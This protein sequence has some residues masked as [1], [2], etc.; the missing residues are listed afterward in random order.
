LQPIFYDPKPG[1]RA[2]FPA[3][4]ENIE[5]IDISKVRW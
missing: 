3:E 5:S 4:R 2:D 1:F